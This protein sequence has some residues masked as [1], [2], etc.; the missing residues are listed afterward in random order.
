M[1]G[2]KAPYFSLVLN[3]HAK[4]TTPLFFF[5]TSTLSIC[6]KRHVGIEYWYDAQVTSPVPHMKPRCRVLVFFLSLS[7]ERITK[8]EEQ[9]W[10]ERTRLSLSPTRW[11]FTTCEFLSILVLAVNYRVFFYSESAASS[12]QPPSCDCLLT[13]A[14]RE[15]ALALSFLFEHV[16]VGGGNVIVWVNPRASRAAETTVKQV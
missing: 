1:Q 9:H 14:V 7:A 2:F 5:F 6:S 12:R 13:A 11:N 10:S 8:Y 4:I 16:T 3:T 15:H